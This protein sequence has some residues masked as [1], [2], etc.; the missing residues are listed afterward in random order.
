MK[1]VRRVSTF[2]KR[3]KEL[4]EE[5][6]LSQKELSEEVKIKT[7]TLCDWETGKSVP[8]ANDRLFGLAD[9]FE[10]SVDYLLGAEE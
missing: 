2:P 10:V 9:F 4:R 7:S 1:Q 6:G 5:K 3:L 8:L